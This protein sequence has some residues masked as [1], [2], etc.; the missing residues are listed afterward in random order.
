MARPSKYKPDIHPQLAEA[1]ATAG[2]TEDEIAVKLG[3]SKATV[4]NWKNEHPEFLAALKAGKEIPDDKVELSLYQRAI[5]YRHKAVKI[6][7]PA[8]A[9]APVYADYTERYPP[10]PTSM[11]FWLKNRRPTKWREKQEI[12]IGGNLAIS[13]DPI[14]REELDP[15]NG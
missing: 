3:I 14:L 4:T 12:D 10:D 15:A 2:K 7:M 13:F 9:K 11:I 5:G 8:G 6:F 1:W